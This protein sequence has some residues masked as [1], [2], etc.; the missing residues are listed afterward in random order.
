MSGFRRS[1]G[2]IRRSLRVFGLKGTALKGFIITYDYLFDLRRGLETVRWAR[3]NS[4]YTGSAGRGE[5]YQPTRVWPLRK[6]LKT[7]EPSLPNT[8]ALLD[9][10][11]GKGR[12][13][14]VASEFGFDVVRGVEI[15]KDLCEIAER[16]CSRSQ[17]STGN[18]TVFEV[19]QCDA[20]EYK[21]RAD[22]NVFFM[23]NPFDRPTLDAVLGNICESVSR[24]P[25]KVI[26]IFN[27]IRYPEPFEAAGCLQVCGE[28]SFSG[29]RFTVF[30]NKELE[31]DKII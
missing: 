24:F 12:V 30:S 2:R 14:I 4:V 13:L 3:P 7:L 9:I 25:R 29:H 19:V 6:M 17:R 22:E 10:G 1:L 16:N 15:S 21:I 26:L 27:N 5:P 8:R 11:C 28:Y 18:V 20:V 31:K 23:F